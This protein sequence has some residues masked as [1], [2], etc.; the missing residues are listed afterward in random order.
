MRIKAFTLSEILITLGIISVISALTI[1]ALIQK[2]QK[3]QTVTQFKKVY[4][5]LSQGFRKASQD[6]DVY[7]L[8]DNWK[9]RDEVMEIMSQYFQTAKKYT[10]KDLEGTGR[11]S[12]CIDKKNRIGF[13][14]QYRGIGYRFLNQNKI[15]PGMTSPLIGN[16]SLEMINGVCIG[17]GTNDATAT[18]LVMVDI[19][20]TPT[21]PNRLGYDLFFFFIN[22]NNQLVPFYG[23]YWSTRFISKRELD[24]NCD[25]T[26]HQSGWSCSGKIMMENKINY[27]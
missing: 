26:I 1:P 18:R 10:S 22:E 21:G 15:E 5:T 25:T 16:P 17:F 24:K 6:Y 8:G 7:S 27:W 19:N 20:G 9:N 12:L 23:A 11:D 14:K 3:T 13:T 2:Y 4:S